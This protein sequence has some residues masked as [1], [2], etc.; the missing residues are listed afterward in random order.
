MRKIKKATRV[1]IL[2][3]SIA[4]GRPGKASVPM[5]KLMVKANSAKY[6]T[7]VN[8]RPSHALSPVSEEAPF[9]WTEIA[10]RS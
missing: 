9:D 10:G 6:G 7:L 2:A 3:A 4:S 1:P 5:N 8:P